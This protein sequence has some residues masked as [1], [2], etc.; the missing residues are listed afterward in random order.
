MAELTES[1]REAGPV[2]LTIPARVANDLDGLQETL[3]D[4]AGRMGCPTCHSGRDPLYLRT[5]TEYTLGDQGLEPEPHPWIEASAARSVDV[6]VPDSVTHDIELLKRALAITVGRL[7]CLT[8]CS[9]FD[10]TFRQESA[11]LALS[12][13]EVRG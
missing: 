10:I 8:C 13:Q 7:G 4:L 2:R 11:M 5:A 1:R 9:G 12:E 3:V 6:L